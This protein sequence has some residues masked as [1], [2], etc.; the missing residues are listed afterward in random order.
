M[1]CDF[2]P[3]DGTSIGRLKSYC[4]AI[5]ASSVARWHE[6]R[7]P[8]VILSRNACEFRSLDGTSFER[9]KSYCPAILASSVA[10]W[11]EHRAP[12][13][14]LSR[15]TCEIGAARW[16]YHRAPEIILSRNTREFRPLDGTGI[17]RLKLYCSAVYC[18]IQFRSWLYLLALIVLI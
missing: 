1:L 15:S 13:N 10:R 6:H 17:E 11:Y 7:T 5:L 9:L 16:H 14:I 4:P 12:E 18:D 8:E 2:R 3:L